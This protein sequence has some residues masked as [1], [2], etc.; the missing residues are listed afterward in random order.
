MY[1][2][3]YEVLTNPL[4][5]GAMIGVGILNIISSR[6]KGVPFIQSLM[7]TMFYLTCVFVGLLI[8]T[9]IKQ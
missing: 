2:I 3:I 6:K 9:Y 1:E 7:L 5:W 4:T 8:V